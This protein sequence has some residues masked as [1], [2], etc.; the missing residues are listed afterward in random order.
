MPDLVTQPGNNPVCFFGQEL[1]DYDKACKILMEKV[2]RFLPEG[3]TRARIRATSR[4]SKALQDGSLGD[5]LGDEA[6]GMVIIDFEGLRFF[7]YA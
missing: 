4:V 2:K 5:T 7:M 6:R 1:E 3:S